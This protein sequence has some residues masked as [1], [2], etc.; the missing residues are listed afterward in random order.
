MVKLKITLKAAKQYRWRK[1]L[2]VSF[3]GAFLLTAHT[4]LTR[5]I[6]NFIFLQIQ[7]Q[8]FDEQ[9][10]LRGVWAPFPLVQT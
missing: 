2:Q 3:Q 1:R 10:H 9:Q 4:F 5:I 8:D 7:K 6:H